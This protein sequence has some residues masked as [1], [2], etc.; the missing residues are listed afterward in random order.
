VNET[1]LRLTASGGVALALATAGARAAEPP[2]SS[3]SDVERRDWSFD[4]VPYLWVA[5]ISAETGVPA[6]APAGVDHFDTRISAGAMFA[7]QAR[8]RS[9]G[10][11]VDFAWLRLATEATDPGPA[12]SAV[13]L[14]SDFIHETTALTYRLPTG[15]K[16]RVDLLAGARFWHVNEN[17]NFHAGALPAFQTDVNLNWVDPV[18]GANL[19]YDFDRHW[20][21]TG[22]AMVG[23]FGVASKFMADVF[24]GGG[25]RFTDWCSVTAGYRFLHEEYDRDDYILKSDIQGLLF[26]V[27][28]HF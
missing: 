25:Y 21:L 3:G 1:I 27:G 15:D 10:L 12:Y 13:D 11:F 8:Y 26:G 2:G 20:F 14:R 19:G 16:L 18:L 9:A 24:V 22:L 7:A 4:V 5:G 6:S 28:F 23:G 17:L